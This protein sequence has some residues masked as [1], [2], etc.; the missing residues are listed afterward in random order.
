MRTSSILLG[1]W[2]VKR[3]VASQVSGKP[4][5]QTFEHAATNVKEELGNSA[6]ELAKSI[7]GA[8]N[9]VDS[10]V[11]HAGLSFIDITS[12][13]AHQVPRPILALGLTGGIPY[14]GASGLTLWLARQAQMA[15]SG[16]ITRI[17]P[18]LASTMLDQALTF[19]VTY[20][21]VM[22][23]FLGAL[24]WGFEMA[25]YGGNKGYSRLALGTAP[26]IVAWASLGMQ[27]MQALVVQWFAFT[28]LW[29]ADSRATTAGWTPK[30]YSQY[31]F[32]LS[33]LIGTCIIGSLAGTSFFGPVAGHG[34]LT[35]ELDELREKRR[36]NMPQK[37][38]LVPGDI[39]AIPAGENADH[40]TLIHRV[41]KK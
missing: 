14:I 22:L 39:E 33:I 5:S 24:H 35:H 3:G 1:V 23:S 32:Y 11:D 34:F 41:E 2:E 31:R 38:G 15:S 7:A 25:A 8:N 12:K 20:G 4:G 13:V 18:G 40:F 26:M 37:H 36:A 10:V 21:A 17:D 6:A 29:Y 28:A 19:Q 9:P 30:W 27:P 16:A